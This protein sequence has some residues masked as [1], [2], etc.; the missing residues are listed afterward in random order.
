MYV[1]VCMYIYICIETCMYKRIKRSGLISHA[2]KVRTASGRGSPS[3]A[4]DTIILLL[5]VLLL[6]YIHTHTH[7]WSYIY[8]HILFFNCETGRSIYRLCVLVGRFYPP[9]PQPTDSFL[10][11]FFIFRHP[12][13]CT[14]LTGVIG[15]GQI[16]SSRK[17][18]KYSLYPP[19]DRCT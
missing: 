2:S 6:L 7:T 14:P 5:L 3:R 19:V 10:F 13:N 16:T 9:A 8:I 18:N 17:K 12:K 11:Y 1:F 4:A 15:E